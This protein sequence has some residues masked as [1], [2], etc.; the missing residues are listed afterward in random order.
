MPEREVAPAGAGGDVVVPLVLDEPP[1]EVVLQVVGRAPVGAKSSVAAHSSSR[2][3]RSSRSRRC[4][5]VRWPTRVT[6]PR[7]A[8]CSGVAVWT[9]P[10]IVLPRTIAPVS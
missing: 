9:V 10:R 5:R 6:A 1:V 4:H 3:E 7:A 8:Y 2:V